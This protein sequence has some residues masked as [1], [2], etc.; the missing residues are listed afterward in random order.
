M[1]HF[2]CKVNGGAKFE[3]RAESSC[4]LILQLKGSLEEISGICSGSQRWIYR[5]R[6]CI[7]YDVFIFHPIHII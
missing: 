5:V 6:C 1:F 3:I 4:T 2:Y 7:S